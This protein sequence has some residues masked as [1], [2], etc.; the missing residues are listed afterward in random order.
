MEFM[1]FTRLMEAGSL[2]LTFDGF[3]WDKFEIVT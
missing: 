1:Y 2:K 3:E